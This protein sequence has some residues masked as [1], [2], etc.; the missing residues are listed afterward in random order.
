M[1]GIRDELAAEGIRSCGGEEDSGL[2]ENEA[3]QDD[4]E[5]NTS[6]LF[7]RNCSDKRRLG[8][9]CCHWS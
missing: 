7:G 2:F 9:C 8:W 4:K 6:I 1:N 5:V 3:V